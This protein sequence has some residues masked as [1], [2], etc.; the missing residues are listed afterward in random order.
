MMLT[1]STAPVL[2]VLS[3]GVEPSVP[4]AVALSP[5]HRV[6]CIGL[7]ERRLTELRNAMSSAGVGAAEVVAAVSS[8]TA[9]SDMTFHVPTS[10]FS[11]TTVGDVGEMI[12]SR[13]HW[14][15]REDGTATLQVMAAT[16]TSNAVSSNAPDAEHAEAAALPPVHLFAIN[17]SFSADGKNFLSLSSN[18]KISELFCTAESVKNGEAMRQL[19]INEGAV[20][21]RKCANDL[22][23]RPF[24]ISPDSH[25]DV[26][27]PTT[28][29]F[30]SFEDDYGCICLP[31]NFGCCAAFFAGMMAMCCCC[32]AC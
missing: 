13:H 11:T 17:P 8:R 30:Y 12:R 7:S 24:D 18:A 21:A 4:A 6:Q 20:T 27:A 31:C 14:C 22:E 28:T 1:E 15:V 3:K 10:A 5:F 23:Q 16:T 26:M 19:S 25:A 29:I 32:Y 2:N 9:E